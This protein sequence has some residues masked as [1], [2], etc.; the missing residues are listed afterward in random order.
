MKRIFNVTV[1]NLFSN[2]LKGVEF[3]NGGPP[4][5]SKIIVAKELLVECRY[6]MKIE[7]SN[8]NGSG[9]VESSAC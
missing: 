4:R 7:K 5:P 1:R 6:I 8:V 3:E 2:A 9:S